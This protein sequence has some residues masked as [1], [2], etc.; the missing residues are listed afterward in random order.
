LRVKK[1]LAPSSPK[2]FDSLAQGNALGLEFG[3]ISQGN[4]GPD[5]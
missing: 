4:R 5:W 1:R 2:G 3:H